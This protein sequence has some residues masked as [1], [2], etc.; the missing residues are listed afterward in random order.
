MDEVKTV[1]CFVCGKCNRRH[2]TEANARQCAAKDIEQE[3]AIWFQEKLHDV[4]EYVGFTR[5]RAGLEALLREIEDAIGRFVRR[6][7]PDSDGSAN[8]Q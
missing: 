3:N 7:R 4:T 6:A 5:D 2:D 1:V 8:G